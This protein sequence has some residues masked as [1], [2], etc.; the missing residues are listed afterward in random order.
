M[1]IDFHVHFF[2]DSLACK[3]MDYLGGMSGV[4]PYGNGTYD[5]LV[6]FMKDADVGL[7]VNQPVA[8]TPEQVVS[9]NR[10]MIET[11]KKNQGVI[12]FGAMHPG[13]NQNSDVSGELSYIASNG[14]KGIKL[15]SEYQEFYPDDDKLTPIYEACAAKGLIVLFH[16]GRDIGFTTLHATPERLLQV[17]RIKG[18]TIVLAHL[19]GY[20][21]WDEVLR[22]LAGEKNI[23]FD[24]AY[25]A[26]MPDALMKEIITGHGVNNVLFGSD[27][28]WESPVIIREKIK[29]LGLGAENENKIFYKNAKYLLKL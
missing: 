27:F 6:S 11:N 25:T 26:E 23:Y 9:I 28:P 29:S 17:S 22:V 2:P 16:S 19:G 8:T 10:K 20:R 1:T 14:I 18:L 4:K 15:H 21:L 7:A 12:S 13:F 24:T 5:A 3:A